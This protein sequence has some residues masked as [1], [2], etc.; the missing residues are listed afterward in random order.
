MEEKDKTWRL[1]KN[2]KHQN[3]KPWL[4]A[5]DFNEV[6]HSWEKEGG[7][8][9]SQVCMDRFKHALEVC[10]LGDLGFVGDTFTWR[11]NSHT[12]ENYIQERLD[13]AVASQA[14]RNRFTAYRVTNGDPHHSDHRPVIID[15]AG[16]TAIR[17]G[18]GSTVSPRF[19]AG[20]LEEE[21]CIDIVKN[22][23]E[24][25]TR[26]EG[27]KV[28]GA[29]QG[30]M[31]VM[32]DWSRNI[33]GDLEKRIH[34]VKRDLEAKRRKNVG[35][36]Q[37]NREHILQF[38]LSRLE[39]QLETYWK[40]RA[41]VNWMKGGD[42]NTKFFHAAASERR[43]RNKIKRLRRDDGSVTEKVE[44]M[45]E[46]ATNYF[47]NLF[48]SRAGTRYDEILSCIDSRV[49]LVMN[50]LLEKEFTREEVFEAL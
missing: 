40:Q 45:K 12:A 6:L 29:V 32:V 9:R 30:V 28:A 16:V 11:N 26:V 19:E 38:K 43:R 35:Q 41:H 34:R 27:K 50:E 48:T 33:L 10:E 42:R 14:W 31:K 23:W 7:V 18:P 4:C 15:T 36:E 8:P 5:G 39:E 47:L 13:R 1:L 37:V 17:H 21:G 3:D 44:E 24:K 46:V 20:W 49:T 22:C 25:E 2:L